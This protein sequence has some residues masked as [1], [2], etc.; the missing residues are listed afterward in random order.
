L[1]RC[2]WNLRIAGVLLKGWN[3]QKRLKKQ[4]DLYGTSVS[5]LWQEGLWIRGF[6]HA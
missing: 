2:L 6:T 1:N 3:R 4:S 5:A